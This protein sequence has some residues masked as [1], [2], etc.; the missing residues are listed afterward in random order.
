VADQAPALL[1]PL[2]GQPVDRYDPAV[3]GDDNTWKAV[4]CSRC[5]REFVNSPFDELITPAPDL[6]HDGDVCELCL[7]GLA[8]ERPVLR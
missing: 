1:H 3:H 7:Y 8:A 6:G 5:G 4:T 2:T